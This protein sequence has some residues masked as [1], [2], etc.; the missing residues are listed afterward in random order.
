MARNDPNFLEYFFLN[1]NVKRF[2]TQ[3]YGDR[4]GSGHQTFMGMALVWFLVASLPWLPLAIGLK[5]F[6][7]GKILCKADF[8]GN[9]ALALS[10]LGILCMTG[11][12]CL[13]SRAL[14]PYLLPSAPLVAMWCA[15]KFGEWKI[16]ET[17]R[18]ALGLKITAALSCAVILIGMG[19]AMWLGH[20]KT[21]KMPKGMYREIQNVQRAT[22]EYADAKFYFANRAPYSAEFY[23]RDALRSHPLE[24]V[25][26][27]VA[28]SGDDFLLVSKRYME[29]IKNPPPRKVVYENPKWIVFAPELKGDE[30]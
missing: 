6:T 13:T 29:R 25:A 30:E 19:V 26:D 18:F 21:G 16:L 1:E 23:L 17:E 11:F 20:A 7:R 4:Y 14:L 24:S 3:E 8:T 22:P 10:L 15:M 2:V 9:P 27:S 12:W 28:N 5:F